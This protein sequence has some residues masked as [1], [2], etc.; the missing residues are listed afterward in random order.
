MAFKNVDCSK[1][2]LV[3]VVCY[4]VASR[5]IYRDFLEKYHAKKIFFRNNE[6]KDYPVYVKKNGKIKTEFV[7]KNL[8]GT[9]LSLMDNCFHCLYKNTNR[10]SDIT[11]GDFW[12]YKELNNISDDIK[13]SLIMCN[14]K[15][16][17]IFFNKIKYIF[18]FLASCSA[19]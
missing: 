16:G 4:G 9:K 3:D 14:T 2:L 5:K 18:F 6:L 17:K 7:L 8:Y 10:C 1:L 19:K 11:I 12:G 15:K 13:Y